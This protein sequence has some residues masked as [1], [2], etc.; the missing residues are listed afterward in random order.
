MLH[1]MLG[2]VASW[3]S[4]TVTSTTRPLSEANVATVRL[5]PVDLLGARA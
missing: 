3:A 5:E 4:F 1:V 2:G